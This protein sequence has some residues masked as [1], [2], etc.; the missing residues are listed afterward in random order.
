MASMVQAIELEKLI[1]HPDNPN[2]MSN[3][4]FG[5]LV[6]NIGRTGRYEPIVVRPHPIREGYFQI[7]NGHHRCQ[8]LLKLGYKAGDCVV[9]D[10]DDEEA[11]ILLATLNRLCGSDELGRKLNLL[12]QLSKRME[13][14]ELAR[15]VP[16]TAKQIER[17]T[18]LKIPIMP[19]EAKGFS[20]PMVFFV[21]DAQ[22]EVVEKA[23]SSAVAEAMADKSAQKKADGKTKAARRAAALAR[24]AVEFINKT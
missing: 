16:Q 10:I 23:L 7:I 14:K 21:N 19:A 9:W 24:I 2:K 8:A 11:E 5:K 6:R 13:S 1:A 4:T 18:N 22:G 3:A 12:R 15:L 20:T 17:L